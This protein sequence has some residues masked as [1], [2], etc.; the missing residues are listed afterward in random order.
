MRTVTPR[1]S[2]PA[3]A[4]YRRLFGAQVIALVGTGL[5][6]VALNLAVAAPDRPRVERAPRFAAG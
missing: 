4:C 5:T 3:S 6:T 2:P 1:R